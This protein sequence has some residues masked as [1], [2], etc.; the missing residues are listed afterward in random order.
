M[1]VKIKTLKIENFKGIENLIIG[2]NGQDMDIYGDNGTGKTTIYDAWLWLLFGKDSNGVSNFE[3]RPIKSDGTIKHNIITAVESV[4][5]VDSGEEVILRKE[6]K[7]NWGRPKNSAEEL[8]LGMQYSYFLNTI[9]VKKGDYD[10]KISSFIDENLFKILTNPIYFNENISWQDRRKEL[11]SISSYTSDYD[12]AKEDEEFSDIADMLKDTTA[13]NVKSNLELSS[14][15]ITKQIESIPYRVKEIQKTIDDMKIDKTVEEI[16]KELNDLAIQ[17]KKY[18][19]GYKS[20]VADEI[21]RL[22]EIIAKKESG[23]Q[24]R[25]TLIINRSGNYKRIMEDITSTENRIKTLQERVTAL[26]KDYEE[27]RDKKIKQQNV[28]PCCGQK[29]PQDKIDKAIEEFNFTKA[30][31]L[32]QIA[33]DGKQLNQEITVLNKRL[34][35]LKASAENAK[36][37]DIEIEK[38][39][40]EEIPEKKRLEEIKSQKQERNKE[41]EIKIKEIEAKISSLSAEKEKIK[42]LESFQKRLDDI[43]KEEKSLT[44]EAAS[45]EDNLEFINK[46]IKKKVE[47]IENVINQN[48]TLVQFRMFK[49]KTRGVFAETCEATVN[50]VPYAN[51][52]HGAKICAGLD[53]IK[54]MQEIYGTNVPIFID[55]RESISDIPDM[56]N[57]QIINLIVKKDA[58]K[59]SINGKGSN[60]VSKE[61]PDSPTMPKLL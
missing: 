38:I 32:K 7:E 31:K 29:L 36:K 39:K 21:R 30:K 42:N 41:V 35:E 54:T 52:N 8:F 53:I 16:D 59:L 45:I 46:L 51:L 13:E 22:T 58:K 18:L 40:Q 3:F 15:R 37:A 49:E 61:K 14:K 1:G 44:M 10:K 34:S 48:F 9:D 20:P 6:A 5:V 2:L 28:C 12:T 25:I 50:G 11:I 17:R 55:N 27:E 43:K 23:K 57:T 4:I 60:V 56:G 33:E 24:A 47:L 19:E 26:R